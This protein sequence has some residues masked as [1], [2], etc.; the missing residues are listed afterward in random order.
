[1]V[2]R[3]NLIPMAHCKFI[4]CPAFWRVAVAP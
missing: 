1:L 4:A 3:R 2:A